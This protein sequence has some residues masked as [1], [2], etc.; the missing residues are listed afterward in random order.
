MN[1]YFILSNLDKERFNYSRSISVGMRRLSLL[2]E[3]N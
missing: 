3:D 1:S 2:I